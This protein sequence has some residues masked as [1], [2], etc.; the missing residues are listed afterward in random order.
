MFWKIISAFVLMALCVGVH[1]GG[2]M[3]ALHW[4]RQELGWRRLLPWARRF[5]RLAS[6]IVVLHLVEIGVWGAY[7]AW[8]QT[9]PRMADALYFSAT[10]YTTTGYGDIVLPE[11]WRVFSAVEALTGILMCG[12]STAFFFTVIH[13]FYDSDRPTAQADGRS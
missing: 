1:A 5:V 13:R 6:W 12:W 3:V 8:Q 10:T 9:I 7:Y 4:T 11:G 2:I